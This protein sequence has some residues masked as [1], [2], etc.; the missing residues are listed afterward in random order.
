L[1]SDIRRP[2]GYANDGP[3]P[4]ADIHEIVVIDRLMCA[5]KGTYP[6]MDTAC[7]LSGAII[8]WLP[9]VGRQ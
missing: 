5:V 6:K 8:S 3:I 9:D 4:L 1:V 7:L 2:Q